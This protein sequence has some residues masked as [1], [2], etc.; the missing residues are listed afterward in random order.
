MWML[1]TPPANWLILDG[2]SFS[3]A[4]YPALAS[5]LGG[6]TL[7]NLKQKAPVGYDAAT[8]PFNSLGASGG[9]KDAPVITHTHSEATYHWH[10]ISHG[11]T[12]TDPGHS[13]FP[14]D[15]SSAGFVVQHPSTTLTLA[16]QPLGAGATYDTGTGKTRSSATGLSVDGTGSDSGTN[17]TAVTMAA[18]AGAVAGTN[19][20]LQ[21]YI[22]LNF[23]IK[24]A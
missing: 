8:A 17:V 4:T 16:G 2:S 20:N 1:S 23:I 6:T 14:N 5:H 18:P 10:N 11:H 21:P 7:P 15:G 12:T 24:A 13:H 19:Q 3:A 22:V 9:S